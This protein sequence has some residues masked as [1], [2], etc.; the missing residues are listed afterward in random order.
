MIW[1][2][3]GYLLSKRNYNENSTIVEIFTFNHGK[4]VGIVYGG[5]SSKIKKF[6]QIGNKILTIFKSKRENAMGYFTTELIKPVAPFF[7]DNKKKI[8]CFL[9]ALSILKILLPEGQVNKKIFNDFEILI[10]NF[11]FKKWI[12]FYIYWEKSKKII[13]LII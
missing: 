11:S 5:S 9:S 12:L 13:N 7:F 10:H 1:E 8:T 6:L 3:Y 4:S 2:D